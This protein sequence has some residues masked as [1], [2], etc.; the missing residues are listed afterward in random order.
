MKCV[1]H[2]TQRLVG[3]SISRRCLT[4]ALLLSSVTALVW[5][6]GATTAPCEHHMASDRCKSVCI[7][8]TPAGPRPANA[9]AQCTEY[10]SDEMICCDCSLRVNC[11]VMPNTFTFATIFASYGGTCSTNGICAGFTHAEVW[12]QRLPVRM[13]IGCHP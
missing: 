1:S 5:L 3:G 2:V 11:T 6:H 13:S 9:G 8:C 10:Q 4:L 12:V 7:T